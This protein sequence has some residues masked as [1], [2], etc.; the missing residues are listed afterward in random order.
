MVL[1]VLQ[2][3]KFLYIFFKIYYQNCFYN[4]AD[5]NLLIKATLF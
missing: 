5:Y 3:R 1:E 2:Q 4:T